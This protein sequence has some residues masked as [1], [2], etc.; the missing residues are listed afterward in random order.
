MS[1]M[2]CRKKIIM[3]SS[4]DDEW[5]CGVSKVAII[6]HLAGL[7]WVK[8]IIKGIRAEITLLS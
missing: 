8:A 2:I 1:C 4:H 3:T 7:L 5:P 6:N